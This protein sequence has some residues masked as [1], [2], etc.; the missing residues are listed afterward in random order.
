MK[1]NR[2]LS[3]VRNLVLALATASIFT[4]VAKAQATLYSGKFTLPFEAHWGGLTL[5]AGDYSFQLNSSGHGSD[6]IV[7]LQGTRKLGFVMSEAYNQAPQSEQ[8]ELIVTRSS[9]RARIVAL[10]AGELGTDFYYHLPKAEGRL[11]ASAPELIQRI[12]VSRNGR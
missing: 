3:M 2:S 1:M 7:V 6:M 8:S 9:G 12:P 4:G 5:P 11:I 10:H